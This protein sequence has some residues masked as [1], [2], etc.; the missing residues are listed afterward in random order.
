MGKPRKPPPVIVHVEYVP[1]D[2]Q[3]QRALAILAEGVRRA[4]VAKATG[5]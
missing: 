4:L 2:E 1:G 3:A 5:K